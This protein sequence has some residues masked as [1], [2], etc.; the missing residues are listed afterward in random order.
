LTGVASYS[1][2]AINTVGL[3]IAVPDDCGLY[4]SSFKENVGDV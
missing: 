3:G 4:L 1:K 2:M